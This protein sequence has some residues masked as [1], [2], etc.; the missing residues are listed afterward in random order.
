MKI[1]HAFVLLCS[2][3]SVSYG[4]TERDFH[5]INGQKIKG[6]VEKFFE[7]GDIL[8]R[9]SKDKQLFRISLDIFTE[10]DQAF[11]KN[12]FAPNHDALPE[13]QR[14]LSPSVLK[15]NSR[16]I[17]SLIDQ[18]IGS[19]RLRPNKVAS[20]EVFLRRA[21]LKI[22]GRIPTFDEANE[23]L[24]N[25]DRST[26]KSE[27]IDKLLG[28]HGYVSHWFNF[29]ADILR[30]KQNLGN[31]VSGR[32]YIDYI[33]E[34]IATNKLYDVW[35]KEML[36]ASGPMWERGNGAVGYFIRDR[37]MQ[38]DNMSNTVRVF[39][40]TSLECAQC[41]DHP[42]DRWSQKQFYEMAAFTEGAGNSGY[43]TGE[44]MST[45]NKLVRAERKRM[46]REDNV[47]ASERIRRAS[48]NFNDIMGIGLASMGNGKIKLPGD[49]QYDNASPN[50]EIKASTIFGLTAELDENLKVT[51]S[52]SSYA[53][54]V[55][56]E[57][58]PRFTAVIVNR[59]WKEAFGLAFIEPLDNMID[60][61]MPTHPKLQLHLEKVMVA[62]NYDI[63][64]FLRIIYN[65]QA[66]QRE[67]PKPDMM[68]RDNKDTIM[69]PEV[70]WVLAGPNLE[71]PTRGSIPY[72]YQGPLMER[73]SGEQ[74]W[75]SLVAL[76]FS[77]V[78]TRQIKRGDS[79]S[80]YESY[81][82]MTGEEL[83]ALMMKRAGLQAGATAAPK[84]EMEMAS[85]LGE[86]INAEC[87]LKPGRAIDPS[88]KALNEKGE[89]IGF[90][91][92]S[93]LNRFKESQPRPAGSTASKETDMKFG[94]PI[95][96]DCPI[97]PGR[98][99]DPSLLAL[100][101]DGD[102]VAFCCRSCLKQFEQKQNAPPEVAK[103]SAKPAHD[104]GNYVRDQNSIRASEV[105]S[106][107]PAGHLIREFGASDRDQIEGSHK[108]ASVTQV[109]NLLNGY[110]EKQLLKNDKVQILEVV[111]RGKTIDTK[112]ENAFLAVLNRE[113]SSSEIRTFKDAVRGSSHPEKD[114]IWVLVNSHEFLFV[115]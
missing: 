29:W 81:L 41:H 45:F 96:S 2:F 89:T 102:T 57:S 25:R 31:R 3:L 85:K 12:N 77:D 44:N 56:S 83:F 63:K 86:P 16:Y 107:A 108:Q 27:L 70:K 73:M 68:A 11:V 99:V 33:R 106:P 18:R 95:N 65:T 37:G 109:L 48:L 75:D 5:S 30:A 115:Q 112:I 23:F 98:P 94:D 97:K 88:L 72:F 51:G 61:T 71:A 40:G 66:F 55:A 53:N 58:N 101:D 17:D 105:G 22:I 74:L 1:F 50:Q 9:R 93:C 80:A 47:N 84:K 67:A 59:L 103:T 69:P 13:F 36:S 114:L 113:P 10:D 82:E 104:Y 87:P 28:S 19:Y 14:P 43:N 4:S 34:S 46:N 78:D 49:Y 32:P 21:Y 92:R 26:K 20:E 54:W 8:L 90:C 76:N 52:R 91:C 100:N 60:D 79:Y 38:L 64:E 7:D 62:L 111:K 35:V 15:A 42:F 39:L 24:E 6:L 110:V